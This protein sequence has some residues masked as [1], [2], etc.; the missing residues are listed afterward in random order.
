M[1][2]HCLGST[3][4]LCK[5]DD[6]YSFGNIRYIPADPIKRSIFR[7]VKNVLHVLFAVVKCTVLGIF[8]I[9]KAIVLLVIPSSSKDIQNQV[10]LVRTCYD[11]KM[12]KS[13]GL[14]L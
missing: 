8:I 6:L 12:H 2:Y 1:L 4:N 9:I 11:L 7:T 5:M 3:V 10:A 14:L 13:K